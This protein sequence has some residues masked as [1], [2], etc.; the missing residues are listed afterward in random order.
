MRG[1]GPGERRG[2]RKKG[3]P[4]RASK[5][6]EIEVQNSG[7]TPLEFLL[8]I[9]RNSEVPR[10]ERLEAAKAAAPYVHAKF[11]ALVK[12][13]TKS[14]YD[15]TKLTDEEIETVTAILERA[16]FAGAEQIASPCCTTSSAP[17]RSL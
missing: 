4:N 14:E 1:S 5:A 7:A 3:T 6:R 10:R 9:M 2:G 11:A 15:L 16:S 17:A 12:I 8:G 13:E